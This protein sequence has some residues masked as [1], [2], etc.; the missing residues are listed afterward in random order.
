M[1]RKEMVELARRVVFPNKYSTPLDNIL[2]TVGIDT[3]GNTDSAKK[4]LFQS[5]YWNN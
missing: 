2:R 4:F 3:F 1:K 5:T